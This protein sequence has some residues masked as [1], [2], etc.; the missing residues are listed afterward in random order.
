MPDV[1]AAADPWGSL[2]LCLPL[3]LSLAL[4]RWTAAF[5]LLLPPPAADVA[6]GARSGSLSRWFRLCHWAS[7]YRSVSLSLSLCLPVS[8]PPCVPL[9]RCLP[10]SSC[11]SVW[12]ALRL[13]LSPSLPLCPCRHLPRALSLALS[14]WPG[15]RRPAPRQRAP[16]VPSPRASLLLALLALRPLWLLRVSS[17][18]SPCLA[19]SR[20]RGSRT[21]LATPSP[22]S[23]EN[24]PGPRHCPRA[25]PSPGRL[26]T[27]CTRPRRG[28]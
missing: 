11:A 21:N 19:E 1:P 20:S 25:C 4:A 6:D 27:S 28:A 2:P 22:A 13:S 9:S 16:T 15:L 24:R 18:R 14:L 23:G 12:D 10:P 7:V 8:V 5:C 26:L 3:C 17:H